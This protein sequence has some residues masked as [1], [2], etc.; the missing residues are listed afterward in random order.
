M[1]MK[2][3]S[4]YVYGSCSQKLHNIIFLGGLF[5]PANVRD[6]WTDCDETFNYYFKEREI[7]H[8]K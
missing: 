5:I 3:H 6:G 1:H 4:Y 7:K 2:V 8:F